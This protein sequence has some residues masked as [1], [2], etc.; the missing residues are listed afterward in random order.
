MLDLLLVRADFLAFA[1]NA[2]FIR[3]SALDVGDLCQIVRKLFEP[4]Q[5]HAIVETRS[6]QQAQCRF[7]NLLTAFGV[8]LDRPLRFAVSSAVAATKLRRS[9]RS[10]KS[11]S[12]RLDFGRR[13]VVF[14]D[15]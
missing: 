5:C 3:K 1:P 6:P 12:W 2:L 9:C 8:A 7:A 10:I 13:H 11:P 15:I 14:P 4:I